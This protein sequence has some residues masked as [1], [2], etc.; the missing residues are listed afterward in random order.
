[1]GGH[2]PNVNGTAPLVQRNRVRARA[3]LRRLS[4]YSQNEPVIALASDCLIGR[5]TDARFCDKALDDLARALDAGVTALSINDL[6]IADDVVDYNQ[7]ARVRK[8][9]RPGEVVR[10]ARLVG[11]NED[12]VNRAAV[13]RLS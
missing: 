10:I 7:A 6:S 9:Q 12:Q 8:L 11:I 1:M 2:L 13:D 4:H 3:D 5:G